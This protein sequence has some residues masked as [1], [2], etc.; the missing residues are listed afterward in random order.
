MAL[1][2][3]AEM[4]ALHINQTWIL[5]DLPPNRKPIG[6][7]WIYRIKYKSNGEIER[8]KAR[9]VAKGFSQT[10]GVDY[11]ETFSPVVKM[12]TVRCVLTLAVNNGWLLH[13]LD[14]NNAFLYGD[15]DEEAPRKW[16]EKLSNCLSENG[17]VQSKSDTSM[18]IK[19]K[20]DIFVVLL[21][22]VD[23]IVLTGNNIKEIKSVKAFLSSKFMIKDLGLLKYFLGIE[24]TNTDEGLNLSQR[25]YCLELINEFG[26]LAAKPVNTPIDVNVS[27]Y[28]GENEDI[29]KNMSVYQ[30]LVGKLIYMTVT[31]PDISYVVHV[32]SQFMHAPAVSHLKIAFRVLKYLK[33][34]PG[35]GIS[36]NKGM[37]NFDITAF[38][39]SDWGKNLLA[40]KSIIGFC[41]FLGDSLISWKIK[42][43]PIVS[44]SSAEAE[45]RAMGA[46]TCELIWILKLLTELKLKNLIPIKMF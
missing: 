45:Y 46:A 16:N 35:K 21:V 36:I 22:Y 25:K 17:F 37:K 13:Q 10:E 31:R 23:D 28:K 41:I 42:R 7:K 4:E 29:I 5:T 44:R 2:V 39:D 30:K 8:Y 1:K 27:S 11:D 6:C 32:L 19:T 24:V 3:N 34:C 43:Q 20:D 40:R 12:V 38:V 18:Y 15:L 14:I 26:L 9:L 33:G